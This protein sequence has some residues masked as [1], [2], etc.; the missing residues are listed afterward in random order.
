[1]LGTR[2]LAAQAWREVEALLDRQLSPLGLRAMAALAPRRAETIV[3]IGCG[4]GQTV[5]QLA[6]H[7][8]AEGKI[9]G[10]DIAPL[11]LD[12]ARERA[13]GLTQAR[14]VE[15]DAAR[16]DLPDGSVDAIYSRFGVM[17]FAEPVTA[18]ANFHRMLKP[19]G[20]LAFVCWRSL[21]ENALDILPL[22][23][24]GLEALADKT[25][26]SFEK[27]D[28]IRAVLGSAGFKHIAIAQHDEPVSSG[29]V[30]EMLA[31]LLKVGPLGR[32][33]R[34]N[35]ALQDAAAPRL[36]AALEARNAN[37]RVLLDAAVWI[38]AASA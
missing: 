12:R 5:L 16:L 34:E 7:V 17:A 33:L 8:G 24:A 38:V 27:P 2:V 18:F 35:P 29:G 19:S 3:D 20:R 14:F 9:V 4:T 36:R 31:V 32:I 15:S 37:G 13:A 11:L 21:D 22:R 28:V 26:F 25:P 6:D 30:D 1:M 23:A 10:V